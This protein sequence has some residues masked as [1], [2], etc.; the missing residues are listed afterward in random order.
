MTLK[1]EIKSKLRIED[2]IIEIWEQV[3]PEGDWEG[4]TATIDDICDLVE[5]SLLNRLPKE[6]KEEN[7][8]IPGSVV[9][10]DYVNKGFNACLKELT[11]IITGEE[12]NSEAKEIK[13][14][15]RSYNKITKG[16]KN[17]HK[18]SQKA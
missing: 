6:K 7:W 10:I 9:E 1:E 16:L 8:K 13:D 4:R 15:L 5:K 18:N 12:I 14:C 2:G 11:E 3:L 17:D